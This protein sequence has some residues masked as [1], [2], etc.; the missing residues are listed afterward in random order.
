MRSSGILAVALGP[1]HVPAGLGTVTDDLSLRHGLPPKLTTIDTSICVLRQ[2]GNPSKAVEEIPEAPA[3]TAV[4]G[5]C[6]PAGDSSLDQPAADGVADEAGDLVDP[7]LEHEATAV[8]LGGLHGDSQHLGDLLRR[9]ALGH[10]LQNLTLARGERVAG[11]SALLAVRSDHDVG[12]GGAEI[13]LSRLDDHL[14]R[15]SRAIEPIRA[16]QRYDLVLIDCPPSL[17][18][19]TLNV[20]S[21]A[22]WSLV[23]I[24]YYAERPGSNAPAESRFGVR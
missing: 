24:R 21:A 22:D 20:F 11:G 19:L 14:L 2:S 10:Q 4:R 13:E 15:L 6:V 23:G 16:A 18:V 8:G 12:N 17:G 1:E 3:F 5:R 7:Q 9:P